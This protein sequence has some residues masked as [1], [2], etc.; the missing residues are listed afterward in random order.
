LTTVAG[1]PNPTQDS[2]RVLR[3]H[4]YIPFSDLQIEREAEISKFPMTMG[5][6]EVSLT[7]YVRML[8]TSGVTVGGQRG[9]SPPW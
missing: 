9:E 6:S 1:L 3:K 7:V 5:K 4:L 8:L 2:I